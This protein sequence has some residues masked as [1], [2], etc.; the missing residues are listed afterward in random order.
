M[1]EYP[2]LFFVESNVNLANKFS[3][4]T[5]PVANINLFTYINPKFVYAEKNVGK[6]MNE[7]YFIILKSNCELEQKIM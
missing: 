7:M 5:L 1:T 4:A 3:K 6:K 2:E